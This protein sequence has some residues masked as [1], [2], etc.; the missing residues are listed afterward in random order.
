MNGRLREKNCLVTAAA[1]GIG[2]AT[3]LAFAREGAR[4]V[5]ADIDR[6]GLDALCAEA[7]SIEAV[8]LDVADSTAIRAFAQAQ[9]PFD[10]LFNCA[11]IV[12]AGNVLECS[13]ADWTRAWQLNVG[14]MF[15]L[16]QALLPGMLARGGGS[17]VNVASMAAHILPE[18]ITPTA[19]FPL[20]LHD[21]AAFTDHMTAV[22]NA[23]PEEIRS[24]IAYGVSKSFVRWYSTSQ[25]ERFNGRGLRIVDALSEHWGWTR[26]ALAGK[27]VWA[28]LPTRRRVLEGGDGESPK[29]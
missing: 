26:R 1:A 5:A 20:A 21:E 17:I 10:V 19:Q 11:G 25:A 18:E 9:D 6:A 28:M 7:R 4:V 14:S 12:H 29:R 15:H 23:F 22:C 2:R 13:D 16:A 24:G 27:T 3:A 8:E